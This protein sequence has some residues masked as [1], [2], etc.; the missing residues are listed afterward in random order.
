MSYPVRIFVL[1]AIVAGLAWWAP[2]RQFTEAVAL[3]PGFE[4]YNGSHYRVARPAGWRPQEGSDDLGQRYMEFN[5]PATPDG[6]YSG[7]ARV[8]EWEQWPHELETKLAQ[9]RSSAQKSGQRVVKEEPVVVKG[10]VSAY[11][12]ELSQRSRTATGASVSL[13]SIDTFALTEDH[14]L[15]QLTVR[16][17]QGDEGDGGRVP[18]ILKSFQARSERRGPFDLLPDIEFPEFK[19]T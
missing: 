6:A 7:Q 17:P 11:R 19:L 14:V 13:R 12:F 5:G 1:V 10:A 15:L 4:G 3:P 9:F 2:W 18:E 16:V 8:A